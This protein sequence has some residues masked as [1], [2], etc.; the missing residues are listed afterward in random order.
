VRPFFFFFP[1]V[2]PHLGVS[3]EKE[4]RACLETHT[5]T[6]AQSLS[7]HH[8]GAK[9]EDP[10]HSSWLGSAPAAVWQPRTLLGVRQ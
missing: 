2:G 8:L 1:C 7:A 9:V 4:T 3:S 10:V 6:T 5:Q